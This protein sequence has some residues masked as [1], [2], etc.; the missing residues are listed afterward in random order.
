MAVIGWTELWDRKEK[1][2][3]VQRDGIHLSQEGPGGEGGKG[4][5]SKSLAPG[6]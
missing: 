4:H 5:S 1:V 2:R 6:G 3:L